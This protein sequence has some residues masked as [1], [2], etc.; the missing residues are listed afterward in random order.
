MRMDDLPSPAA[1]TAQNYARVFLVDDHPL[2]IEG[3]TALI[4]E[5]EGLE[6][7]GSARSTHEA[8]QK[9]RSLQPDIA[10]VDL[11]MDGGGGL[12]LI[13]RIHMQ[14][15]TI[16]ILVVSMYEEDAY[17]TLAMRAGA[18]GYVNKRETAGNIIAAIRTLLSG[19]PHFQRSQDHHPAA[20]DSLS[21]REMQVFELLARGNTTTA[22][23]EQ[24]NRSVKTVETH[25]DHIK[26]KLG[27]PSSHALTVFAVQWMQNQDRSADSARTPDFSPLAP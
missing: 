16:R 3:I 15:P 19:K 7:C 12:E 11:S 27:L 10:L 22:I 5:S 9:L 25:R 24:L 6:V 2:V 1:S 18:M 20:L 14:H 13:R 23:A 17:G 21:L 26:E 8:L 4:R